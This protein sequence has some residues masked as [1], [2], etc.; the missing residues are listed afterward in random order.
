MRLPFLDR[1]EE[2][3]R[4]ARLRKSRQG[5]LG[6]LFGRRRCG[7]SRLIQEA[8]DPDSVVYYLA[9]EREPALLRAALAAEIGRTLPGFEG[10]VYPDWS[11]V[12]E[13]WWREA[14]R[15]TILVI[16]EFPSLV[17]RSPEVPSILQ[18]LIDRRSDR[19][20]H[21]LICGSSQ[22]M[23]QGL[24]LDRSAPL[25]GRAKEV[26]KISPLP[27]GWIG[28]ALGLRRPSEAVG[29]YS[30]WGGIPRYWELAADARGLDEAVRRLVLDPLGVLHREPE[31]LLLDDLRDTSQ[32]AS[33]LSLIGQ[34]CHRLSE[35][36]GRI[37]KP[38]TA[39]SR[40]LQR[41]LELDLIRRDQ[42]FGASHRDSKRTLYRIDDPF[43]RFWFR[44]VE[45]NRTRLESRQIDLVWS[46]I[47][48]QWSSHTASVWEDLARASVAR[49]TIHSLRWKPAS[50]WWGLG[51]HRRPLEIDVVAES[52]D[53]RALLLGEAT[54]GGARET[55]RAIAELGEKAEAFPLA[56][57]RRIH[58][59]VWSKQRPR[60]TPRGVPIIGPKEVLE[61]LR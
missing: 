11:A 32:A 7:K 47:R 58:L 21:L 38:A 50:S 39:L 53:G 33:I 59:A 13:R 56:E 51:G 35:I 19:G 55:A 31:R 8:L 25:Y 57:R 30:V 36:A 45:P 18:G 2:K 28:E 52:T 43:L 10:A 27:A 44:F 29:A 48:A 42:P 40:P 37:Q 1:S 6:V 14:P 61:A 26:L 46:E 9:D 23:M 41:L 54:W 22:R 24:V 16:D 60:R 34:G 20:I 5:V 17:A 4:L 12:F 15:G 49:S 3:K